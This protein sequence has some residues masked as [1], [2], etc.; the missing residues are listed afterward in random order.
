MSGNATRRVCP[1]VPELRARGGNAGKE[2]VQ[3]KYPA[4]WRRC[5]GGCGTSVYLPFKNRR[6]LSKFCSRRC[7]SGIGPHLNE[8]PPVI[9]RPHPN[10]VPVCLWCDRPFRRGT[11]LGRK[12]CSNVCQNYGLG[13]AAITV[14]I[15]YGNCI[16]CGDL[17]VRPE[18][19]AHHT[20][21]SRRCSRR[22]HKYQ[23]RHIKRVKN[24]GESFTLREIAERDG[25]C[26]H[27]C[28]KKVPDRDYAA[29]DR[30]PTVDHLVPVSAGGSHTRA[31]VALAHNRC[32]WERGDTPIAFQQRLIA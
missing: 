16:Q 7:G 17:F 12:W 26:C 4:V 31:N 10:E 22:R 24:G 25:W 3:V 27:I 5:V 19:H 1:L 14:E 6:Y 28:G 30:D 32:N 11:G 9:D 15:T 20:T 29:R 21:C 8:L 2:W 13:R 18:R 23:R